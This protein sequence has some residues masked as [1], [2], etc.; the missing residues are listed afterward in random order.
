MTTEATNIPLPALLAQHLPQLPE[1]NQ[2]DLPRTVQQP[3]HEVEWAKDTTAEASFL[4]E[5]QDLSFLFNDHDDI[6][7]T[8]SSMDLDPLSISSHCTHSSAPSHGH[9]PFRS[10]SSTMHLPT[11][12][13]EPLARGPK[14]GHA[15]EF[16]QKRADRAKV[17][18]K[19]ALD[20]PLDNTAELLR[21]LKQMPDNEEGSRLP[22][23]L[24]T[25]QGPLHRY[26]GSSFWAL[27]GTRVSSYLII[28]RCIK[29]VRCEEPAHMVSM[30]W[31]VEM[32]QM[33]DIEADT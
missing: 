2:A 10:A 28:P 32:E 12:S 33:A 1:G 3:R 23:C 30:I 27:S 18:D 6:F 25:G 22:W 21:T 14:V 17:I 5:E 7:A 19:W 4:V 24:S 16:S 26:V 29:Y 8:T 9:V 13:C 15:I 20:D 31:Q 11:H